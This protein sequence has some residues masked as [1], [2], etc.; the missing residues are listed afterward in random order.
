MILEKT[1][2]R[3]SIELKE[4]KTVR[5]RYIVADAKKLY[6]LRKQGVIRKGFLIYLYRDEKEKN[7]LGFQK[8][9]NVWIKKYHPYVN[10][11]IINAL[12][13]VPKRKQKQWKKLWGKITHYRI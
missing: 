2:P 13:H 5:K 7:E 4:K 6:K 10:C 12:E 3:I 9:A 1:K 8:E 11:I